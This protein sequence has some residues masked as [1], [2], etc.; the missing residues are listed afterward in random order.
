MSLLIVGPWEPLEAIGLRL[1]VGCP[2]TEHWIV[3]KVLRSEVVGS[4]LVS[5]PRTRD[6][7]RGERRRG[8]PIYGIGLTTAPWRLVVPSLAQV[9]F[10]MSASPRSLA[11]CIEVIQREIAL[12]R[13]LGID[14]TI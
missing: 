12:D 11:E 2:T 4:D 3:R 6:L 8:Q 1:L 7:I 5:H 13:A 14:T 10:W 9:K